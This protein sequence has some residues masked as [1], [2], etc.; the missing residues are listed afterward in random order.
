MKAVTNN[1]RML[2]EGFPVATLFLYPTKLS[3]SLYCNEYFK[4]CL[5]EENQGEK[6]ELSLTNYS[7]WTVIST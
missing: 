1:D 4:D 7:L 6:I 3:L 2:F 5:R